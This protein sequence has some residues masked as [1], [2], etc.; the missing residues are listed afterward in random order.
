MDFDKSRRLTKLYLPGKRSARP[1]KRSL[2]G[3]EIEMFVLDSRGALADADRLIGK[4]Q[5][6]DIPVKKECAKSMLE[7]VC[8]PH[9]RLSFTSINLINSLI[10][11]ARIAKKEGLHLFPFGTYP[12]LNDPVFRKSPQYTVQKRILGERF[13]NAGLCSGFHQHYTLPRG[14]FD[15][16]RKQLQ[17]KTASSVQKTMLDSY[18]ML[19]AIDPILSTFLQSSPYVNNQYLAKDSRM[20]LYRGGAKL[21]YRNGLYAQHQMFG[22]LPP[23]KQTVR[24]LL[25]SLHNKHRK[26]QGLLAQHGYPVEEEESLKSI[27]SVGWNPVKINEKGTLEYRGG[28]ATY[29]SI[30]LGVSTMM[31]FALRKIQQDFAIV[32]PMDIRLEDAFKVEN[33]MI[34]IPPH[35]VVRNQLQRY[36]AYEGFQ[37]KELLTYIRAFARFIKREVY[38]EYMPMLG[39]ISALLKRR[40][41]I[42]DIMAD[43]MK[44][45][46]Y[47]TALPEK[48][49]RELALQHAAQ[50]LKDLELSRDMVKKVTG[51]AQPLG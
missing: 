26:W 16:A 20:V 2:S 36:A 18:N 17:Y 30:M 9:S 28:D 48:A 50:F 38:D 31:K 12:G 33:N 46:G 13:V 21:K 1:I 19:I 14:V 51:A 7:I 43:S 39:P 27:F 15:L 4:A 11:L 40:K 44:R 49:A 24:D 29:L 32:V 3:Y 41:S 45:K 42:A 47:G 6:R 35:S 34:F 5:K 8:M 10:D 22:A 25:L 23:Y 37:N